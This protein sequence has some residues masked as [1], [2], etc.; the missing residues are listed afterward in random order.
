MIVITRTHII[1]VDPTE[2]V[3]FGEWAYDS[4][5]DIEEGSKIIERARHTIYQPEY[6]WFKI[7]KHQ[8]FHNQPELDDVYTY[9][10]TVRPVKEVMTAYSESEYESVVN[11]LILDE[12]IN[13]KSIE[14][15][16]LLAPNEKLDGEKSESYKTITEFLVEQGV[17]EMLFN[18]YAFRFIDDNR[19][20][21][22]DNSFIKY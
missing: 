18:D 13:I 19:R 14:L 17:I 10:I 8:P 15:G 11:R 6:G 4:L 3:S 2:P 5:E 21:L 9:G 1:E 22:Y 16:N 20:E 12:Y 7:V